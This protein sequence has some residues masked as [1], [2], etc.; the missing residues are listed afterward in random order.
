[1]ITADE[2]GQY[3]QNSMPARHGVLQRFPGG[4][5]RLPAEFEGLPDLIIIRVMFIDASEQPERAEDSSALTGENV[6]E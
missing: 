1:M 5:A 6:S 2:T 3:T 4:S